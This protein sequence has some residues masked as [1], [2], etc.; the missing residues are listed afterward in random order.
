MRARS[1]GVCGGAVL[2]VALLAWTLGFGLVLGVKCARPEVGVEALPMQV[3]Q[4]LHTLGAIGFV[5]SGIAVLM[6]VVLRR[7]S[8]RLAVLAD[9]A[10]ALLGVFVAA[11]AAAIVLGHGSGLEYTSWPAWLTPVPV[12]AFALLGVAAVV[13]LPRLSRVSG[14]GAWLLTV[15]LALVPAGLVERVLGAGAGASVARALTIEWHALDTSFAGFNTALYG[16]AVL[17]TARPGRGRPLRSVWLY[18]LAAFALLSTFGHH[19]YLS[20]QPQALKL[21]AFVASM[22]GVASFLRHSRALRRGKGREDHSPGAPLFRSAKVWTV[23]AVG[24]GILL[25]IPQVNLILHGTHAVVGHAMGAMIGVNVMI[26]LGGLMTAR[27]EGGGLDA[28]ASRD[29]RQLVRGF[30]VVLGLFVATLFVAGLVKGFMR[31]DASFREYQPIVRWCLMPVP[32]LGV[33]LTILLGRL[34]LRLAPRR[35]PV[36][37]ARVV[38]VSGLGLRGTGGQSAELMEVRS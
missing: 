26:V 31:M 35:P 17:L 25:A 21:T 30:D 32:V 29:V 1:V 33:A 24:S 3:V 14:E 7:A 2:I 8:A 37:P 16:L 18:G 20:P 28:A 6:G 38:V 27:A 9:V 12:L 19:H 23:F 34:C 36:A 10:A 15:G 13:N 4:P 5:V 22:L 11:G